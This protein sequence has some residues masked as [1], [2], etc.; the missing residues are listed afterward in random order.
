VRV[1]N[2]KRV[3]KRA[4]WF[5][6]ERKPDELLPGTVLLLPI[7][8]SGGD[9]NG[10]RRTEEGA[11]GERKMEGRWCCYSERGRKTTASAWDADKL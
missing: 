9:A 4:Y 11:M 6:S 5:G 1:V 3:L 10:V 8:E 2:T 7:R